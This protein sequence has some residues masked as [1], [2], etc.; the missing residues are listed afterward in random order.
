LLNVALTGNVASGKSTVAAQ[1]AKSGVPIT[2][3][4]ELSRLVV[5]P[6][7]PG[8]QA[9]RNTFGDEI[10]AADGTLDRARLRTVIL[11]DEDARRKLEGILHPLI[12]ER[13]D[14]W[15]EARHVE[16]EGL[17]VSEIPLLFETGREGDFD[18]IVLVDAFESERIQRLIQT[19]GLN[20]EEARQLIGVQIE[21]SVKQSKA[22]YVLSNNGTLEDLNSAAGELLKELQ[23]RADMGTLC[24]DLHLHTA[25]SFD[26]LSDPDAVLDTALARGLGRIAITDHNEL[27]VALRMA[28]AY[29]DLVIPGEEIKTA[30]SIDVIGLYLSELIPKGTPAMETI[31]R[32]REQG[33]VPYLPHPYAAGKKGAGGQFA[34]ML[35]PLC[36]VV[37]IFN[38]RL[39][40]PKQ[41][42]L[43]G[44]LADRH[45][46]LRGGGS[47]AHTLRELGSVSVEVQPHLN[48]ASSLRLALAK[49]RVTGTASSHMVHIAST[50]AKL[51]KKLPIEQT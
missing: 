10:L 43:A 41:N 1:W 26:C 11:S 35:A 48:Q 29:P 12:W 17:V 21:A 14:Q 9:V 32:I 37:E 31:E 20:V 7:T 19:R 8:I 39:H 5:L 50:W 22:D 51:R 28:D 6:G 24:M 13:R 18:V 2:S 3:A 45:G 30:E 46:S 40:Q 33:G 49:G 16:G 47:D 25:G 38:A 34:E 15:L 36:D 42:R 23:S 4:D 44:E 27:D